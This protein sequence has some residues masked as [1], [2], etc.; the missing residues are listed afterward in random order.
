MLC[1]F[2]ES[3][4]VFEAVCSGSGYFLFDP[5][6][7]F[8]GV[9]KTNKSASGEN[10]QNE[11]FL[12]FYKNEVVI[13]WT[14]DQF[15]FFSSRVQGG[16]VLGGKLDYMD[17]TIQ[18]GA[19][20]LRLSLSNGGLSLGG[21]IVHDCLLDMKV[22]DSFINEYAVSREEIVRG[23][24]FRRENSVMKFID[25]SQ[26]REI[27]VQLVYIEIPL[28]NSPKLVVYPF[29]VCNGEL[30]ANGILKSIIVQD[31][32]SGFKDVVLGNG[33]LKF[34]GSVMMVEEGEFSLRTKVQNACE[35]QEV[36]DLIPK[37]VNVGN[38]AAFKPLFQL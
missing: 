9:L 7:N 2:A 24:S 23:R 8:K 20:E 11:T 4:I 29:I 30:K 25:G 16:L 14:C 33:F 3:G 32:Q 13:S 35:K 31:L 17:S 12:L 36:F 26:I 37:A 6:E 19:R 34:L 15:V 1:L 18:P 38:E 27:D 5:V 28:I 22:Q 21:G 10:S